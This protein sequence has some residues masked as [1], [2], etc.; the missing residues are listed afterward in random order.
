MFFLTPITSIGAYYFHR[1]PGNSL[2]TF[3]RDL[4]IDSEFPISKLRKNVYLF[5]Y[6]SNERRTSFQ[7]LPANSRSLQIMG[8]LPYL[9][10]IRYS[11]LCMRFTTFLMIIS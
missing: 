7:F 5:V 4:G 1:I 3:T 8:D 6:E 11:A 2:T 9:S 10:A